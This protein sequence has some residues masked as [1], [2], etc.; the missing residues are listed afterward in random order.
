MDIVRKIESIFI[1]PSGE[2]L[3]P[4]LIPDT[5]QDFTCRFFGMALHHMFLH[6]LFC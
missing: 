2:M 3:Y 6:L 5:T 4:W 1:I